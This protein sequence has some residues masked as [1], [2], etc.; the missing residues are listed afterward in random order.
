MFR[1]HDSV[2]MKISLIQFRIT[3]LS[4]RIFLHLLH[5]LPQHIKFLQGAAFCDLTF[6]DDLLH[7]LFHGS[8]ILS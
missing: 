2:N 7:R 8:S 6:Q 5:Q 4:V 1:I 3:G